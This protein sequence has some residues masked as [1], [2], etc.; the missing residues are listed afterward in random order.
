MARDLITLGEVAEHGAAMIEVRCGRCD[1]RGRLNTARLLA[2]HGPDAAIAEVMRAQVGDCP[3]RD[4]A[5]I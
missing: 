4:S 5:Q 1:R 3:K 2:E